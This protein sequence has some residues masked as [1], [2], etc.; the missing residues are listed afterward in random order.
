MLRTGNMPAADTL[1]ITPFG[2][3]EL[4]RYPA[5]RLETLQA[6]CAADTL[7]LE[8][9]HQS[10]LA[11]PGL[12]IANDEHGAL[13]IA[14]RPV[15][16]WTDSALAALAL[17][18]NLALNAGAAQAL[19]VPVL[20]STTR[21]PRGLSAVAMRVPK[22]L[23][24]FEYQLACLSQVL[25][26]G[27]QLLA[28]GMDKHLSP[29][30]AQLLERYI[31]PTQRHRGQ[32]KARLFTATR[33]ARPALPL[34]GLASYHCELLAARLVAMSNVFSQDK[35]DSGTRLLLEHLDTQAPVQQVLDLACGNGV[36][37][38]AA[39]QRGLARSAIFCDESAMAVASA[40]A[41]VATLFANQSIEVH[42]HHGDGMLGYSGAQADLVLCNPPFHLNHTVDEFVG[43]RLLEHSAS[44]LAAGGS[45]CLVANRHLNYQPTLKRY[46][47]RVTRV[48]QD[49]KFVVWQAIRRG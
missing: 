26:P 43:R 16:L 23:P 3:V 7:L 10:E 48:A 37:G 21:P 1:Y 17:E 28:A 9:V 29:R 40:R 15:A 11:G 39:L 35:L 5:R 25:E 2:S 12:L 19:S 42:F 22:Q 36:L 14:A 27:S 6:W 18:R 24:Y 47:Q 38:L 33:D 45:L 41:N 46:F 8:A 49:S 20:W 13:S 30:V 31:G 34:P 4:Q 32:R 44:H